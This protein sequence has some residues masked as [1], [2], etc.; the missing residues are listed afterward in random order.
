MKEIY[1]TILKI[2]NFC[3]CNESNISASCHI[4]M[5]EL[6][7]LNA[8][9]KDE[10]ITCTELAK[11]MN[12]SLSRGSRI[13]DGLVKKGYILRKTYHLDRRSTMLCLT[14]KGRKLKND[15]TKEQKAFEEYIKLELNTQEIES[16][17]KGLKILEKFL[18]YN[19]KGEKNVR[20][21]CNGS[22]G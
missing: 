12:L 11:R 1:D 8:M 9:K 17:K 14:E 5:A 18:V 10:A 6:K 7:G 20:K 19:K 4:G 16:I 21:N 2:K 13:I 3:A 15:I 22:Q